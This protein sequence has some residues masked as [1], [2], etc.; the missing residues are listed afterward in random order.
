M[1]R[2]IIKQGV[3]GST[4]FLPAKWIKENHIKPGDEIDITLKDNNLVISGTQKA[5]EKTKEIK[6]KKV[7]TLDYIRSIISS[8]YKAGYSDIMLH[9]ET[10]PSLSAMNSIVNTFTGLEVVNH[11]EN[12]V[13]IKSFLQT[14]Q[15]EIENLIIKML[16]TINLIVTD[17]DDNWDKANLAD[18]DAL[19]NINMRKMRD[20]CLRSIHATRYGGDKSYDYYDLVTI[21]EKISA[22]LL[23]TAQYI[24]SKKPSYS[25]FMTKLT[26]MTEL[27][28]K[29]YLKKEFK[30]CRSLWLEIGKEK[31]E[32]ISPNGLKDMVR[33][34][35]TG[36][37]VHYNLILWLYR[38]LSSRLL[39]ISD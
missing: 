13:R 2:K 35:D 11:S 23:T 15:K 38:H 26:D 1:R 3:G 4:V 10:M 16:Q 9:F 7:E 29:S 28:Y 36:L 27:I 17:I 20:H 37:V 39:S 5:F 30:V 32:K 21:L 19:V 14:D 12:I 34:T 22:E 6:L 18:M 8:A 31:D 24:S 33:K 25:K